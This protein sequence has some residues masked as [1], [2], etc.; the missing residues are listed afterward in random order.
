MVRNTH[1]DPRAYIRRWSC[2]W[3]HPKEEQ[4]IGGSVRIKR[5]TK[6]GVRAAIAL[7][8]SSGM[9]KASGFFKKSPPDNS[10][11]ADAL[12]QDSTESAPV[13]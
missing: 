11:K 12:K 7:K 9:I 1:N 5:V 13:G 4:A 8:F 2:T 6:D 3:G 10:I